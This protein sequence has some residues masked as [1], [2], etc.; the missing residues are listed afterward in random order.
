MLS[1]SLQGVLS[2]GKEERKDLV[3]QLE[4]AQASTDGAYTELDQ[5]RSKA[6]GISPI[7]AQVVAG[8]SSG[9][10]S[11]G[12]QEVK[13]GWMQVSP[14]TNEG[15]F[16]EFDILTKIKCE[17]WYGYLILKEEIQQVD[18]STTEKQNVKTG[19]ARRY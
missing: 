8:S 14:Q 7:Q 3:Y 15:M 18:E 17:N 16:F 2:K 5:H 9:G 1:L 12:V 11:G 10:C 6:Y 4:V 19:M 13:L